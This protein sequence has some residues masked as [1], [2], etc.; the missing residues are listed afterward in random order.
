MGKHHYPD[1]GYHRFRQ[2]VVSLQES[3]QSVEPQHFIA[4]V[5]DV[6]RSQTNEKAPHGYATPYAWRVRGWA[7]RA[8]EE[9][10]LALEQTP[11]WYLFHGIEANKSVYE[12]AESMGLSM[13]AFIQAFREHVPEDVKVHNVASAIMKKY[14]GGAFRSVGDMQNYY[15]S[16]RKDF[17]M[18]SGLGEVIQTVANVD[19]GLFHLWESEGLLPKVSADS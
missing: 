8:V 11:D 6:A 19:P 13:R 2:A 16:I 15:D 12:I 14:E 9:R 10:L 17:A 18:E 4:Y 7:Q 5:Q 3:R 1:F